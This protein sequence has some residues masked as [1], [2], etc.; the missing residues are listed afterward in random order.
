MVRKLIMSSLADKIRESRKITIQVGDIKFYGKRATTEELARYMQ[1]KTL[2]AE[3]ARYHIT[4][5]DGVKES[6]LIEGG[7]DDLVKFDR[8]LFFEIIGDKHEWYSE[9]ARAVLDE[10]MRRITERVENEK[11]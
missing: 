6:D 5:W 1:A 7:K 11:K 8:E 4:G 3:V 2:D 10:S 9:I